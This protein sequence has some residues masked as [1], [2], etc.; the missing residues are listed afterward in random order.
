VNYA[1]ILAGGQGF[2]M[3]ESNVPKQFIEL[4]GKPMLVYSLRAAERNANLKRICVVCPPDWNE[5][6]IVWAA[7]YDI[8]KPLFLADSGSD[9]QKSVHSGLKRLAANPRDI[10]MIMTSVCPLVSQET[11][12]KHFAA[13]E[14][15]DA[16]I[17][18]VKAADAITLS[19]DGRLAKQVLQKQKLF[20]QQGPQT[21]RYG[22]LKAG[23]ERY[24]E[25]RERKEVNEDSE[26][27][28][29]L[30]VKPYMVFGDR[31]CLKVTYPEDLRIVEALRPIFNRNESNSRRLRQ[32]EGGSA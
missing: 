1:L 2:R 16:C 8:S 26:L 21:F 32:T 25:M 20:I 12:D 18:V 13:L 7:E 19:D 30:G 24:E 23:H 6:V 5:R 28:L 10:V 17:T 15:Y 11:I 9:R 22:V 4:S 3:G 31:F 29:N 27:V 14:E